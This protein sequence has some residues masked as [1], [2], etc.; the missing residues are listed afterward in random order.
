MTSQT[1]PQNRKFEGKSSFASSRGQAQRR[2]NMN[3]FCPDVKKCVI[4]R[5]NTVS[6]K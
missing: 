1:S 5:L 6:S 2:D 3:D 4:L